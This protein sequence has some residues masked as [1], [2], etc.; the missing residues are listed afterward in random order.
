MVRYYLIGKIQLTDQQLKRADVNLSGKVTILDSTLI[1][2]FICGK[3]AELGKAVSD[4]NM[5]E[6]SS[7]ETPSEPSSTPSSSSSSESSDSSTS[8]STSSSS[9]SDGSQESSASGKYD[10]SSS[11]SESGEWAGPY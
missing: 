1:K 5:D 10:T 2:M 9:S 7:S 8:S 6:S 4:I 3:V 11:S